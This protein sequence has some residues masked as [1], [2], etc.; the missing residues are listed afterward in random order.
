MSILRKILVSLWFTTVPLLAFGAPVDINTANAE[1]LA[2][3]LTGIGPQKADAIV[4]YREAHGP[5]KSV[6]ELIQV[7]GI[8]ERM[9]EWNR[10]KLTV[11]SSPANAADSQVE[12]V[13]AD[14]QL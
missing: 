12:T 5:F 14:R 11:G 9:L 8:G 6:D 13:E 1:T 7:Q 4:A 10:S 3:T 2:K